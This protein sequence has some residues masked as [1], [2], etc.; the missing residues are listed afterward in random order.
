MNRRNRR[1]GRNWRK[2]IFDFVAQFLLRVA[3]ATG[4]T[5]NEVNIIVYYLL[6]PLSWTVMFDFWLGLPVT[7]CAL[8]LIWAG[9]FITTRHTF[10]SWCDRA[11]KASVDFLNLF[12][13]WGSNYVLSSVIICVVVPIA[14][15]AA[16]ILLLIK[17]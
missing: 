14:I 17:S 5:Y 15:Y 4:S 8:A 10:R 13:R 12:N 1:S 6:I 7:T 16:L 2:R 11:F 3:E 9:I